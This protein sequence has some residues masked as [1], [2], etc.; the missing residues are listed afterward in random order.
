M[1]LEQPYA[2]YVEHMGSDLSVVNAARQSFDKQKTVFD[3]NDTGLIQFLATG[4]RTK[5]WDQFLDNILNI[6]DKDILK[7]ELI[8]YKRKAQHWAPF[9]HP[10]A[11]I[12]VRL[13]LFLARQ[14]VKHQIGG[15]WSE[16]SRRYLSSEVSYYLPDQIHSRPE[17]IKQGSDAKHT[18]SDNIL[19]TMK[20]RVDIADQYYKE[21]INMGVAPEEARMIL[22]LNSMTGITWTGSLLFWARVVTQRIDPHAQKA[23]QHL[24]GQINNIL[25]PLYPVSWEALVGNL[26][27]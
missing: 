11:T 3:R 20:S 8:A 2:E 22:P 1:K 24:A 25:R 7:S 6:T 18:Y 13:P 5:E 4:M 9:A 15:T 23:A 27:K 12:R 26:P 17:D 21:L 14:F 16:E 19:T 10:H